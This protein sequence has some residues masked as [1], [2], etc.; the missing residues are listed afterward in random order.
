[1]INDWYVVSVGSANRHDGNGPWTVVDYG[2]SSNPATFGNKTG[3]S[4]KNYVDLANYNSAGTA[5]LDPS[6]LYLITFDQDY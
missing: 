4:T 2:T 1:M 3:L 6:H 5:P